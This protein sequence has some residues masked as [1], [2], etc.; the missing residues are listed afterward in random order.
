[1]M[2]FSNRLTSHNKLN[3]LKVVVNI[4]Y[5]VILKYLDR[6]FYKTKQNE[7]LHYKKIPWKLTYQNKKI[8][9]YFEFLEI[10]WALD[11]LEYIDIILNKKFDVLI[12]I[13]S[14]IWRISFFTAKYNSNI[15]KVIMLDPNSYVYGVVKKNI[16]KFDVYNKCEIINRWISDTKK[17]GKLYIDET[18]VISGLWSIEKTHASHNKEITIELTTFWD[19]IEDKNLKQFKNIL[20]KIDVEGHEKNVLQ[21]IFESIN[22]LENTENIT[23]IVEIR[24]NKLNIIKELVTKYTKSANIVW[25]KKIS[26]NDYILEINK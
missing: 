1:M 3:K 10:I 14:N 9:Y 16:H 7:L 13:W 23:I 11:S 4:I 8:E 15:K 26:F 21:S 22:Q 18:N 12:D 17:L 24:E 19:I 5:Y 2:I 25:P 20:I 6:F